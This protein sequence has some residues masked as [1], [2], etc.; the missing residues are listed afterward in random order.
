MPYEIS[1]ASSIFEGKLENKLRNIPMMVVKIDDILVSGKNDDD[2][3]KNLEN[4][5]ELLVRVNRIV[6]LNQNKCKV[7]KT[8]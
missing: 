7:L 1:P 6:T 8:K 4:V 5:F 2:N 3:L